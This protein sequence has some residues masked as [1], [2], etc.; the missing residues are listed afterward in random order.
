MDPYR[1]HSRRYYRS[2]QSAG[3]GVVA[4][5]LLVV[6]AAGII[7]FSP[8]GDRLKDSILI[9]ITNAVSQK[10]DSD[11]DKAAEVFATATEKPSPEPSEKPVE[12]DVF[13]VK[14]SPFFLLQMGQFDSEQEAISGS[15]QLQAMG[16]A[17]YIAEKDGTFRL[18]AAA[19]TDAESLVSVQ[20]QIR[21][22][23][24]ISETYITDAK[25]VRIALKGA[26][27]AIQS[28]ETG[29][30]LLQTLPFDLCKTSLL[31]DKKETDRQRIADDLK[32]Y[33]QTL[34]KSL[35][36]LRLIRSDDLEPLNKA[37][38][39]YQNAVSTFLT[40]HD[41]IGE[42]LYAGALKHLQLEVIFAYTDFFEA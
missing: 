26:P 20:Q 13:T 30:E 37:L 22:D 27:E 35:E 3:F 41:N 23:G 2:R 29:I 39:K 33:R 34:D 38:E 15:D 16:G 10:V 5:L 36:N 6:F 42:D 18:F 17:G 14:S 21:K 19:Y 31:Y 11:K 28:F 24:Y 12:Q 32:Q 40:M 1:R 4:V 7:A 9:P 25:T 8:I